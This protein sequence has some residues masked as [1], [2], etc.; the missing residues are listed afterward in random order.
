MAG[1]ADLMSELVYGSIWSRP[2]LSKQD[3]MACTLAV[4][5][6]MQNLEQLRRHIGAALHLG[7]EPRAIVEILIQVG[8][9]RGFAASESAMEVAAQVFAER[10]VEAADDK[11]R[12]DPLEVLTARGRQL[13]ATLHDVRKDSAHASPNNPVTSSVYPL[14]VQYCYGE[15]WDRPG[16]DL[17]IRGLCAVAAFAALDH[18][19]L[20]RKFAISALNVG[21]SKAEVVEAVVQVGPYS[22]FAFMLKGMSAVAE[23]F[24]DAELS[25]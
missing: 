6:S 12:Y 7:I 19:P 24:L 22:G 13:Q 15:I 1:F 25:S 9:Y 16:L 14:V 18:E 8:I 5:C 20:L 10:G 23:V 21:A 11:G 2:G 4:L 17:R 3:R